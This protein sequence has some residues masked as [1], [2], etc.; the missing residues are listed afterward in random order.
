M[1]RIP[2]SERELDLMVNCKTYPAVSTKYTETVCTGGVDR[3]GHFVRL[4]PIPFRLLTEPERYDRWDVIRVKVYR[5]S[6]DARPESWHYIPGTPI[7][8]LESISDEAERW[9][10]MKKAVFSSR[11]EMEERNLTNGL[12]E[13][14]PVKFYWEADEK[15]WSPSQLNVFS[16]GNL[17]ESKDVLQ[18]LANRVPWQF[19][20]SGR[21]NS[22]QSEFDGKVLAW[23]YYQGF[24]RELARTGDEQAALKSVHDRVA[25]SIFNPD[26]A[27]FA[28]FGTHSRFGNWMISALYHV[29]RKISHPAE[30][31]KELFQ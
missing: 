29:P 5:D 10:W 12:V 24:R 19:R 18:D 25:K 14:E 26:R 8:V 23:S 16:Q 4:Y 11:A 31:Q 1:A 22:S 20:L 7:Q 6:K 9:A 15:E 13:V 30:V 3:D 27:V 28:I 2:E 21:E 17:F